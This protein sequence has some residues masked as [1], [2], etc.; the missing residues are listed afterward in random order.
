MSFILLR[1]A[2]VLLFCT[3]LHGEASAQEDHD[4]PKTSTSTMKLGTFSISLSVSDINVSLDFY[5]KLGFQVI[6]GEIEQ[7]W[8]ILKN[9]EAIIGLFQGMFEENIMTF[10]PNDVRSIQKSLKES[11]VEITTEADET[12]TGPAHI[13][14]KD[15]DGNTILIDQH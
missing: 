4:Q 14:L 13:I 1:I 15:P 3:L 7:N 10:N 12:T 6:G 5:Q 2:C 8:V 11:N 9:N